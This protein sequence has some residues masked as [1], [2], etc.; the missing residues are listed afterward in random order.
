MKARI[1]KSVLRNKTK[2]WLATINNEQ[3]REL[4]GENT[5]VTGG[6]IASMLLRE[7]VNDYDIYFRS[8]EAA[9]AVATYYIDQFK[10]NPPTKFK[11]GGGEVPIWLDTD[12]PDRIRVVIKSAGIASENG[13]GD[14]QYFE[15]IPDPESTDASDYVETAVAVADSKDP[16]DKESH[17][18]IFMSSNAITLSDNIQLVLRFYGEAEEIHKNY[19]FVHCTNYWQSWDGQLVLHPAALEALLAKELRYVGSKYPLASFIRTRKF[20]KREWTINAGQYL[21]MAMQLND[22]DLNNVEVLEDQLTGVDA[23]YFAQVIEA[24]KDRDPTKVDRSYLMEIID[25]IF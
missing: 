4:A 16:K 17:R 25:R 10:K 22:L 13:T 18:P 8:R 15:A 21:K 1:I 23:A 19:D 12:K 3:V 24:L 7:R 20:I 6:C 11:E 9:I 2:A 5:I 14:Y